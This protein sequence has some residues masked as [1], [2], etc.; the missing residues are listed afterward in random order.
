MPPVHQTIYV[1][2]DEYQINSDHIPELVAHMFGE[3]LA[4]RYGNGNSTW[5]GNIQQLT[6]MC[7]DCEVKWSGADPA[8]WVCGNDT[9]TN[10]LGRLPF[11][12]T[13]PIP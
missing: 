10:G 2:K 1:I 5:V 3:E 12:H 4:E 8:C 13:R 6:R 11:R 9:N 7:Q